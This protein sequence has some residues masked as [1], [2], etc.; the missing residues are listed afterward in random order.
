MPQSLKSTQSAQECREAG[1]SYVGQRGWS[2]DDELDCRWYFC[3]APGLA[4]GLRSNFGAQLEALELGLPRLE[5]PSCNDPDEAM[6]DRLGH[7]AR[8]KRVEHVLHGLE[9]S[10]R[11]VLFAAY[12]GSQLPPAARVRFGDELGGVVLHLAPRLQRLFAGSAKR[13]EGADHERALAQAHQLAEGALDAAQQA[14]AVSRAFEQ[15]RS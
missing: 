2:R 11:D 6:I 10:D 8:A 15:S 4:T 13:V 9:V 5:T 1:F 12:G 14:Y 3:D 7:A